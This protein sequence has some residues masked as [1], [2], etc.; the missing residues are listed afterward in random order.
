MGVDPAIDIT[1]V[2]RRT[3]LTL[4]ERHLPGTTAWVYGSR[5][6]WTSTPQSD[7]DLV[8]FT[9]PEQRGQVGDLR[10][11]FE[12]SNLPFR[13]DLF[14]WHEVT[15]L[16]QRIKTEHVVLCRAT[17]RGPRSGWHRYDVSSLIDRR[18]LLVGDGY[19]AR[20]SELAATG[21]P[22]A[23][24]GN[25]A[26]GFRFAD[27]DR[28][29]ENR[30]HA[31]GNKLSKPGDVVFT[32]KGT[33]G[34]FALVQTDTERFVYS[35]QLC[36]WRSLDHSI[37]DPKFLYY[38]MQGREFHD[39]FKSVSG[40][41]DMAEYV[42]LA[43]Q[44]RMFITAPPVPEQRAIAHILGHLDDKIELSRRMNET[45]E[46][47][48]RALFKS[49]FVDFDPVRAKMAGRDTGLPKYRANMFPDRFQDSKMGPIPKGWSIGCLGDVASSVRRGIDP[50]DVSDGTPYVGLEHMPRGSIALTEWDRSERVASSKFVFKKGELL[51][52][53]LRPYF[54][55]VGLA[56]VSG[57]CST[58]IVVIDPKSVTW[59]AFSLATVSSIEFVRYAD[60]TSTGTKMPRTSWNAMRRYAICLPPAA[61]AEE[62]QSV[63]GPLL[64]RIIANVHCNHS[65][66]TLR[67]LLLPR[68]VSGDLRVSGHGAVRRTLQRE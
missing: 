15:D 68:L 65:L 62:F 67:N 56:P 32:S 47:M 8:V 10:E 21:P 46:T 17:K 29:S 64:D 1:A 60:H 26:F 41:T 12:E 58:D 9:T 59:S 13:V 48:A 14:V 34:R 61:V 55:K 5:A 23:R 36:F 2:E 11:A 4:L 35:P 42:S 40:Q 63:V 24:A 43:D 54:H 44:R 38:W 31:V 37:I 25:I 20:N 51:F 57:I 19:R 49:W 53:K 6:K 27:A 22:F 3:V 28:L 33:V 45:L 50:K 18:A 52:G 39:Q 30:L 16:Q 66:D 7:L